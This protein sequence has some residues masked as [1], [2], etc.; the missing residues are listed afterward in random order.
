MLRSASV[1]LSPQLEIPLTS[2]NVGV[3]GQIVSYYRTGHMPDCSRQLEDAKF[4]LS[5]RHLDAEGKRQAW[6]Q[7]RAAW[8]AERRQGPS[9]EDVWDTR[10]Q[11]VDLGNRLAAAKEAT[12]AK[13]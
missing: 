12:T 11:P 1:P 4:C 13:S 8:W 5:V 3:R 6:I 9:S 10:E 2:L 7:R